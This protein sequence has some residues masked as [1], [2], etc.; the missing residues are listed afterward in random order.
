M[1]AS[2]QKITF[3]YFNSLFFFFFFSSEEKGCN[4][5]IYFLTH[6]PRS[7]ELVEVVKSESIFRICVLKKS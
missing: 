3:Q 2:G 7:A 4:E 6:E 1:R 5:I